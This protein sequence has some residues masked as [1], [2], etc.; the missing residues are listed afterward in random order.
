MTGFR[1]GDVV[2]CAVDHY[3]GLRRGWSRVVLE[4]HIKGDSEV[5]VLRNKT[6]PYTNAD[7]VPTSEYLACNF[8][9]V[10][11]PQK[12]NAEMAAYE[13]TKFIG[14]RATEDGNIDASSNR[15]QTSWRDT[16]HEVRVDVAKIISEGEKWIVVQTVMMIEGEEP[17]P[18]I[19]ITEYR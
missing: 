16:K 3:A 15:E 8:T 17:R 4:S 13:R 9:F 6:S 5:I 10:R 2:R 18:P 7:G 12:E 1:K 11:R 19:R 14:V